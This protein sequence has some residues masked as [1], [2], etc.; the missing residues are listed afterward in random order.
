MEMFQ[1]E[2]L[3]LKFSFIDPDETKMGNSEQLEG[4]NIIHDQ[5]ME[6]GS[7]IKEQQAGIKRGGK[8]QK[9]TFFDIDKQFYV[10]PTHCIYVFCVDLRTNSDYFPIQH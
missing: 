8:I 6:G 5:K 1:R 3:Q 9:L 10:L 2:Q 4:E 7:N